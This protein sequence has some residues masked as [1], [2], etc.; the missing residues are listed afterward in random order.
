M[1]EQESLVQ[2]FE[3]QRPQLQAIAYRLL[4]RAVDAQDAV[5]EAWVRVQT[6]DVSAVTHW[7]GWLRTIVARICID[8]LRSRRARHEQ[9]LDE[10]A[11]PE[12]AA[13]A[14]AERDVLQAE[15][16]GLALLVLLDRLSPNE[17]LAFALHD[18]CG[19]SF[20]EIAALLDRSPAATKKLASRARQRINAPAE[21]PQ[22]ERAHEV[23]V[24]DFLRALR[25][26]DIPR[27]IALLASNVVRRVDGAVPG[28]DQELVGAHQVV[29]EA[30]RN[31]HHTLA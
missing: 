25:T 29:E 24:R 18:L 30:L 31:A 7:S 22:R 14:E 9:A 12:R 20:E 21:L 4:G 27:L 6:S 3:A 15:S 2:R 5:Q 23:M 1:A 13:D 26:A 8:K 17:R 10:S 11:Q 16:V 19:V 28:V